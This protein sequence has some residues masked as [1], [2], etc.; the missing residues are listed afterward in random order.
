M[1]ILHFYKRCW[2]ESLGGIEKSIDTICEATSKKSVKNSVLALSERKHFDRALSNYHIFIRPQVFEVASTPV[3]FK[4]F[5]DFFKLLR[6]AELVHFHY[7]YPMANVLSFFCINKPFIVTYHSD[8]VKQRLLA[9]LIF[10]LD[11]LFLLRAKRVIATSENYLRTSKLL[12]LFKEKTSVIPL[13]LDPS[14]Y[15]FKTQIER[16]KTIRKQPYFLFLGH[17]RYYKGLDYLLDACSKVPHIQ[18]VICGNSKL[19]PEQVSISEKLENV[20]FTGE[21]SEL[22]KMEL[23]QN[24]FGFVF[25]S[26]LRSEAFGLALLEACF[27]AKP[28]ICCEIGTGTTHV[29]IDGITGYVVPPSSSDAIANAMEKLLKSPKMAHKLGENA[30]KRA[31][32]LLTADKQSASYIKIYNSLIQK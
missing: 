1:R 11:Y 30:K 17:N 5:L 23:L 12:Q 26:N 28:L 14:Q 24:C 31:L 13:G 4:I 3:S 15:V 10:P 6:K 29:N 18:V 27:F 32:E 19:S 25:P 16:E 9:K 20:C 22:K 2:P 7:P 8:I 21:V